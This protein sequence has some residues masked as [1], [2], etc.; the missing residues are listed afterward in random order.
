MPKKILVTG[1]AGYIG[2]H[3]CKLLARNGFTPVTYDNLS[4]GNRWAVKWGPLIEGDI[5]NTDFLRYTIISHTPEAV[6][7]FAAKAY[8]DESFVSPI[9]YYETN[10]SGTLS[11]MMALKGTSVK[12]IVFSSSCSVYG[13]PGKIPV[14]ECEAI[15][16]I[17]P[18]GRTKAIAESIIKDCAAKEKTRYSILRYFNAAGADPSSEIGE[19]HEPETHLVPRTLSVAMD[20]TAHLVINGMEH[21]T[22][23]GTCVRDFVHV[24]DLAKGHFLAMKNNLEAK[25]DYTVNLGTGKGASI[26]EIVN[27][28]EQVT[29]RTV[30]T[31][32]APARVGDPPIVVADNSL[33]GSI[34]KWE[35]TAS[36]YAIIEDAYKWELNKPAVIGKVQ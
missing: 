10:V 15:N 21:D 26:K 33:A 14:S 12:S 20:R 34:L 3:T 31:K 35:T 27:A 7:H 4:T 32:T 28:V 8:V 2:S 9:K 6:I 13:N 23:D 5:L 18:Y 1:G 24:M 30:N 16:P 11:L 17:S 22:P 36:M 29:G 25:K 19:H